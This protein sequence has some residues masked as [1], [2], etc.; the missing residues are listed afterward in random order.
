MVSARKAIAIFEQQPPGPTPRAGTPLPEHAD[1]YDERP[2][3]WHRAGRADDRGVGGAR[4]HAPPSPTGWAATCPPTPT[5]VSQELE[6][7]L[8]G[9]AAAGAPARSGSRSERAWPR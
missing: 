7:G 1:L 6:E 4:G 9:R 5:P 3:A 2:A 8:K